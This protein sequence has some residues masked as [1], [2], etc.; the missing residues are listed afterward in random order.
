MQPLFIAVFK[1]LQKRH[2]LAESEFASIQPFW[3]TFFFFPH[4]S[5]QKNLVLSF[6]DE[7]SYGFEQAFNKSGQGQK[8]I[9]FE[10]K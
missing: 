1:R 8:H 10:N 9:L 6:C 2:P 5:E 3:H 4:W 7:H